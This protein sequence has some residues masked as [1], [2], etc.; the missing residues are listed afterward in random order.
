MFT[1]RNLKA[2]L[3]LAASLLLLHAPA[4]AQ[5]GRKPPPKTLP[6]MRPAPA[7]IDYTHF[8]KAKV[9]VSE[10][11]YNFVEALNEQGRLGYRLEK[12]VSYGDP[13]NYHAGRGYSLAHAYAL[14]H[15]RTVDV[16]PGPNRPGDTSPSFGAWSPT[17]PASETPSTATG[18]T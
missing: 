8:D 4:R 3:L 14:T 2:L 12:T 1:S 18:S 10:G 17:A 5:S 7:P 6:G 13:L 9:L 16:S 11:L 15:C